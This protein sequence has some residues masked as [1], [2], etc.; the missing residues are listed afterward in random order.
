MN[1]LVFSIPPSGFKEKYRQD[2][3]KVR[4]D[5]GRASVRPKWSTGK[6]EFVFSW[7]LL[8]TSDKKILKDFVIGNVGVEFFFKN[9]LDDTFYNVIFAEDEFKFKVVSLYEAETGLP[10]W[11]FELKVIEV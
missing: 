2:T 3:L 5:Q 1:E 7:D 8:T 6:N 4:F 9:D 11:S 10:M